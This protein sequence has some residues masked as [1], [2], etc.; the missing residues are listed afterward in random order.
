[1]VGE[2]VVRECVVT[3]KGVYNFTISSRASSIR[4]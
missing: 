4:T 1:M 2:D 3:T